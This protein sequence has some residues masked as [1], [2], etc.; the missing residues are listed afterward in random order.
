ML[1]RKTFQP[2]AIEFKADAPGVVVARFATL[3]VIDKDEDVTLPGAFGSQT[4]RVAGYGHNTSTPTI[5]KGTIEEEA[6]DAIATLRINM[7][8][9][10]GKETYESLKFDAE[11][12]E[13]LTE[14]SYIFD[15]EKW[16]RGQHQ[17]RD[18]RFLE[19]LRVHSVD[20]VFL[21]AGIG[22]AT[23][24]VKSHD[25]ETYADHAEHVLADVQAFVARSGELAALREKDGRTLSG[26]HK[27]RLDTLL[28]G[29]KQVASDLD[30]FLAEPPTGKHAPPV[31]L[32]RMSAQL[33]QAEHEFALCSAMEDSK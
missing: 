14:W 8:M 32:L 4:V 26:E 23:L 29:V 31:N 17:G 25:G 7:A 30:A 1:Q 33:A 16:S 5:G 15:I 11:N 3:N 18:V 19:A 20:P 12:G 6:A 9:M 2:T 22:T 24:A 13:P 21:G 28:A 27:T 10:E